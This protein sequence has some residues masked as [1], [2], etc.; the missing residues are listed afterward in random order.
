MRRILLATLALAALP[1]NAA[2]ADFYINIARQPQPGS[3][4]YVQSAKP[5]SIRLLVE[6]AG[7]SALDV[8]SATPFA[9]GTV[10]TQAGDVVKVFQPAD[11]TTPAATLALDGRPALD[12]VCA[13]ATFFT[14]LQTAAGV[15][16]MGRTYN[17]FSNRSGD[18]NFGIVSRTGTDTFRVQLQRAARLGERAVAIQQLNTGNAQVVSSVNRLVE[19][20]TQLPAPLP[21]DALASFR[22]KDVKP[23]STG[24]QVK[25][26]C[27]KL[28]TIPCAGAATL[29]TGSNAATA[30]K[31]KLVGTKAF[32][33][34]PGKSKRVTVKLK[35][36]AL[37]TLRKKRKLTVLLTVATK[38]Q[39][40]AIL[41]QTTKVTLRIKK[42]KRG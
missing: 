26:A 24:V 41:T 36:A 15:I 2:A 21:T 33:I 27:S 29:T 10:T 18:T 42:K 34:A 25:V 12:R 22:K 16:Q 8:S 17:P 11:S 13:G 5:G 4:M 39:A 1:A 38:N 19:D 14:G 9:R 35:K 37:K 7:A 40:G 3:A 6:R 30:A 20:C 28:S 31:V 23:L 32:T